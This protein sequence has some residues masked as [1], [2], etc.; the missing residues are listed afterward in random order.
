M[1]RIY[2]HVPFCIAKCAYCDF[3]S[4]EGKDLQEKYVSA[5]LKE[6]ETRKGEISGPLK[7]LYF[8]GGTPS[9]LDID[10]LYK[11][12]EF[13]NTNFSLDTHSEITLEANPE[14]ITEE[15]CRQ[16]KSLGINRLSIGVQS[17]NE[18]DLK[19]LQRVH[20]A[21]K[22]KIALKIA[23]KQFYNISADLIHGIPGAEDRH[24]IKNIEVLANLGI[25]HISMYSL[26]I[27]DRSKLKSMINNK[28]RNDID[29]ESQV[30]QFLLAAE[31]AEKLG[32]RQYE[33][34]NFCKFGMEA[35]HN[36]AYWKGE[37]YAGFG[38]SAHS[39]YGNKRRWNIANLKKYVAA[40]ESEE[41]YYETETIGQ[42]E[43]YNEF[44]LTRLRLVEGFTQQE[45]VQNFGAEKFKK[46]L[47][48]IQNSPYF[49]VTKNNIALTREGLLISDTLI[50]DLM[51]V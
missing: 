13:I 45:F 30:R 39:Y 6:M 17:F 38:P 47:L 7:S 32:Y 5:L 34:S 23:S 16:Y 40:L 10:Y 41:K 3:Y 49:S 14:N 33:I 51:E 9:F 46:I 11:I 8:G 20:S 19:Y 35:Q 42:Q 15:K 21:E 48:K 50:S 26:S 4:V 24:M 37:L 36:T 29:E 18:S 28:E 43:K 2:I 1:K 22:A 25:P 12:F 31:T 27:E 44:I